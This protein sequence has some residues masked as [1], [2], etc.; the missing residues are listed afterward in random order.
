MY[1]NDVVLIG[2]ELRDGRTQIT[3]GLKLI[4]GGMGCGDTRKII[5]PHE[6]PLSG[7]VNAILTINKS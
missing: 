4:K 1:F 6:I 7:P 2:G 5:L 3:I